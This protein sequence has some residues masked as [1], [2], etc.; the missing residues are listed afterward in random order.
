[1]SLHVLTSLSKCEQ[2]C[3]GTMFRPFVLT[4]RNED[5]ACEVRVQGM[6]WYDQN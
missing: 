4:E 2:R 5:G 3:I 1:M 6:S